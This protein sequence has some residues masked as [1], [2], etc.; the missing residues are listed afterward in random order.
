MPHYLGLPK[1]PE[2]IPAP[3]R[4]VG[5]FLSSSVSSI[6]CRTAATPMVISISA[7]KG[8]KRVKFQ[9]LGVRID[10]AKSNLSQQLCHTQLGLM[11]RIHDL[12]IHL[13][14]NPESRVGFTNV[15]SWQQC[16]DNPLLAKYLDA[17]CCCETW[18]SQSKIPAS[19]LL[20][21]REH[22]GNGMACMFSTCSMYLI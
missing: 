13:G 19:G 5:F 9:I 1:S 8:W 4:V 11:Q 6:T 15:T 3:S 2:P 7:Q 22:E 14:R 18:R 21:T 17:P 20:Q 12:S 16:T 10:I